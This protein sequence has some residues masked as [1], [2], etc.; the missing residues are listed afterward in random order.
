MSHLENLTRI[1]VVYDALEELGDEV[2]FVGGATV[3]L[4]GDRVSREIRP[5][6]PGNC[7][8]H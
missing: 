3:S 4:Y 7:L 1:K 6:A 5:S 2:I 8:V